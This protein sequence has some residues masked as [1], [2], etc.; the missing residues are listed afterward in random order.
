MLILHCM[1]RLYCV[2][3]IYVG[4]SELTLHE[5]SQVLLPGKGSRIRCPGRTK[6]YWAFVG[7][8][9]NLH[10]EPGNVAGI[11]MEI[12]PPLLHGTYNINC[13]K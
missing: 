5:C 8:S 7:F 9:K 6:Y 3:P 4:F 13:E 2:S 11:I 12:A 10:T 1:S